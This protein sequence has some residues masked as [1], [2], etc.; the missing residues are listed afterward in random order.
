MTEKIYKQS[1]S[2]ETFMGG[3]CVVA[4]VWLSTISFGAPT[5]SKG[6]DASWIQ[7]LAYAFEHHF[8]A[9]VD[10][11]FTYGPLGYIYPRFCYNADLFYP[12]I[13]WNIIIGLFFAAIF[14]TYTQKIEGKID[15]FIYLFLVV[16]VI[17]SFAAD[18][19]YF[20]GIVASVVLAISPPPFI[21]HNILRYTTLVGLVLLFLAV[22]SLTKFTHFILAGV[23]VLWMTVAIWHSYSRKLALIIPIVFTI[24]LISIWLISGQSLFNLP[25]Y[26]INSLQIASGYTDA[27]SGGGFKI[28]Q[29]L[30]AIA[31]IFVI[32]LMVLLGCF[33]KPWQMKRFIIAGMVFFG[34]FIAWK[35]GFVRHDAYHSLT[36]FTFVV[37]A[38]FFIEYD[39]SMHTFLILTFR[40]L[41]YLAIFIALSGLFMVGNKINYTP[42]NFIGNWYQR[43]ANNFTTL[44][45]LPDFKAKRDKNLDRLKQKHNLPKIRAQV[46]QATVDIF[47]WEQG[48]VFLNELNWHPR[49]VF[50]SYSVYTPPLLVINGNFYAS[51]K[52][53][54]F[55]IFKLQAIDGQFPF[56]NDNEALKIL[57]RDYQ[58]ILSEKGYLLLKRVPRGQ[59][60]VSAGETVLSRE[61]KIGELIDI[62]AFSNKQLLLSLDIHKSW[63]GHLSSRLYKMPAIYLEIEATDGTKMSY[64]IIPGMTQSGFVINPL[65]LNQTDFVGWYTAG[66][67]KRIATLRVIVKR[68]RLWLQYF[69]K[70]NIALKISENKITPY[71]VNE[72][73][74][75]T[76]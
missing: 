14:V 25:S 32:G 66:A 29:I 68:E 20:L 13:A 7:S 33:I 27:Q 41:R 62:R 31:N 15:K 63:L 42:S 44:V 67:L 8:Q 64:R 11:I 53:P 10:Y 4:L 47:S 56:M 16:I 50:Q 28:T 5:A 34:I 9:G 57:L 51:V 60:F 40:V 45:N 30:L 55:V 69:F 1:L 74:L 22:I 75:L 19:R 48:V 52:A 21:K 18:P 76:K 46:G 65:I 36:F 35:A 58:P 72:V 73:V 6:L 54:E 23:G 38:P 26:I 2:I 61:I 37:L 70:T 12:F 3:L 24:F 59:G 71:P 17:S 39:K 49:P 43:I